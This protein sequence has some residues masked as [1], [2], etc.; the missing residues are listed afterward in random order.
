VNEES[1]STP[2]TDPQPGSETEPETL[3]LVREAKSGDTGSFG[4]LYEKIAP[5]LYTWADLR[6]RR[7]FRQHVSPEDVVQEVW[8]RAWKIFEKFDPDNGSFRYWIFRVAK[9]VL[10]EALRILKDPASSPGGGGTTRILMLDNIPDDATRITMR[11]ARNESLSKCADW[12]R[13]LSEEDRKLVIHCGLEGLTYVE[14]AERLAMGK[15]AVAKRWQRLREK[16]REQPI[17]QQL[18]SE[19]TVS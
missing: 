10:Y 5:A 9:N 16:L 19:F 3:R 8:C 11:V 1:E 15:E 7:E 12:I 2:P 4:A 18:F 17:P 6:I 13:S 14:T